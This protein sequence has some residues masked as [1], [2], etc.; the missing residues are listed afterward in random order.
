MTEDE[1]VCLSQG[2]PVSGL[3]SGQFRG[4]LCSSAISELCH[5][6]QATNLSEVQLPYSL[7]TINTRCSEC[8]GYSEAHNH[9]LSIPGSDPS[10]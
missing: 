2:F 8:V 6:G 3:G 10:T 9:F 5:L 7:H 1:V 4:Q